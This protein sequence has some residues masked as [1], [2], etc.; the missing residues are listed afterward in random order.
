MFAEIQQ[1][2]RGISLHE[3]SLSYVK[4]NGELGHKSVQRINGE[5]GYRGNVSLNHVLLLTNV[6]T[7]KPFEVLVD[8][9]THYNGRRVMHNA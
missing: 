1:D 8:L 9:I 7:G 2:T 3:F 4:K 6:E 5:R